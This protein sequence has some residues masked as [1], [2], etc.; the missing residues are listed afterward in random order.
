MIIMDEA[1][2]IK[3]KKVC[4]LSVSLCPCLG[5]SRCL[6]RRAPAFYM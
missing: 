3:N 4:G 5:E 1:H 2:Y 6:R